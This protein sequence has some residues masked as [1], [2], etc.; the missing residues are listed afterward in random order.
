ME[1]VITLVDLKAAFDCAVDVDRADD[2][3]NEEEE[4][5]EEEADA[6]DNEGDEDACGG[7][8]PIEDDE[9]FSFSRTV[10]NFTGSTRRVDR[11][12]VLE[13]ADSMPEP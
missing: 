13:Q 7:K 12:G 11:L 8:T 3:A 2:D 1:N 6:T 5:E 9:V 4:E 10:S